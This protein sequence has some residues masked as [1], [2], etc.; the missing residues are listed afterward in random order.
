LVKDFP[1]SP[2]ERI[3]RNAGAERVSLS[4]VKAMKDILLEISEKIALDAIA[5]CRH[6]RRVTVNAEDIRLA[7]R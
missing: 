3:A 1:L 4:A 5:A 6:A 2:L 7:V